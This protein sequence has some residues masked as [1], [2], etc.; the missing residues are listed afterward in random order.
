M[1]SN[2]WLA[3]SARRDDDLF[4]STERVALKPSLATALSERVDGRTQRDLAEFSRHYDRGFLEYSLG[5]LDSAVQRFSRA[6]RVWPEFFYSDIAIALT[7][8]AKGK[9]SL[10]ARYYKSYLNKLRSYSQGKYG[11][12]APIISGLSSGPVEDYDY[13]YSAVRRRLAGYGISIENVR[14]AYSPNPLLSVILLLVL[15]TASYFGVFRFAVPFLKKKIREKNP[16]D[17]FWVCRRCGA[18]NTVLSY[19]CGSCGEGDITRKKSE[20]GTETQGKDND[21][22]K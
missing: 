20:P 3:E 10:A 16:P 1:F 18:L 14:P 4:F 7:Y 21:D 9:Y 17:G 11:I 6:R 5:N 22:R 19:V 2:V 12:S 13:A 8:E 15:A